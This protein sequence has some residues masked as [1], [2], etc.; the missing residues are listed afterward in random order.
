MMLRVLIADDEKMARKRLRR[1]LEALGVEVVAECTGGEEVL[2]R[3]DS[4]QVDAAFLD[5]DMPSVDGL[6]AG[7]IAASR[8]VPVVFVTAHTEHAVGAFAA[9]AVHYL[10]K[11]V[12]ATDLAAA[13]TRLRDARSKSSPSRADDSSASAP[14]EPAPA[15]KLILQAGD[16][17]VFVDIDQISHAL[18]DGHLVTVFAGDD[19][20]LT[21]MS[22][23]DLETKIGRAEFIR[24]H[25]RGLLS[26]AHVDRLRTLPSGGCLA[27]MRG[28]G[29]VP[30]SRQAARALRKRLR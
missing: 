9:G 12:S 28:G 30:V 23:Q 4:D 24:V 20:W 5:I 8:G 14:T 2:S 29:E 19:S 25:R 7:T 6:E 22:L 27:L 1:L 26:L 21:E 15:G 13:V 3:L 11:P 17:T 16:D 18:Y 10:L